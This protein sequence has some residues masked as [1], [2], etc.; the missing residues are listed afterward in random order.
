MWLAAISSERPVVAASTQASSPVTVPAAVHSPARRPPLRL[1]RITSMLSGPGATISKVAA[2]AKPSRAPVIGRHYL[3][4]CSR[5]HPVRGVR[6]PAAFVWSRG[7]VLRYRRGMIRP[8]A[9]ADVPVLVEL[10]VELADFEKARDQVE[11][12][13]RCSSEPCLERNQAPLRGR[14]RW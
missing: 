5:E 14:G 6:C 7:P 11:I 13:P 2:T 8:A 9:P 1:L 12:A 10:I 3:V 4:A